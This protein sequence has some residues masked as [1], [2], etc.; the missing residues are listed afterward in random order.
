M[1]DKLVAVAESRKTA[2]D[3]AWGFVKRIKLL[4][5]GRMLAPIGVQ[6]LIGG[7]LGGPLGA[8]V[9]AVSGMVQAGSVA[10]ADVEKVKAA[11][12]ELQPEFAGLLKEKSERSLPQEIEA[13]RRRSSSPTTIFRLPSFRKRQWSAAHRQRPGS[14]ARRP[15]PHVKN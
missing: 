3:K 11:Y 15:S 14:V 13:L 8:L 7:T 10:E 4:R 1:A 2:V 5:V 9:G 12:G 6:A